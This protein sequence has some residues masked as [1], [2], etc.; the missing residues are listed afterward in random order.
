VALAYERLAGA[1]AALGRTEEAEALAAEGIVDADRR[2]L[3]RTF[4]VLLRASAADALLELG[5]W[6]EAAARIEEGLAG[7]PTGIEGV[8]LHV[9]AARLACGQ[10]EADRAVTHLRAARELAGL[11]PDPDVADGPWAGSLAS[12]ELQLA[13]GRPARVRDLADTWSTSPAAAAW[14]GQRVGL[15]LAGLAAESELAT[16]ARVHGDADGLAEAR[17]RADRLCG[18]AMAPWP[19]ATVPL[20]DALAATAQAERARMDGPVAEA[21]WVAVA[22]A[23]AEAGRTVL[24]AEMELRAAESAL[25]H[26]ERS[27]AAARLSRV[28]AVAVA[29]G[30]R[31]LEAVA[32]DLARR[33]RLDLDPGPGGAPA[34]AVAPDAAGAGTGTGLTSRELEVLSLLAEGRTNREIGEALFISPKT[35]S[36][37]VT[38]LLA[39]LGVAGRVEAATLALRMGIVPP[40]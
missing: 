23:W 8:A 18:A 3:D 35:V 4:G 26:G 30:V 20:R 12:A 32:R 22:A 37:H 5:R 16:T 9:V 39:K 1:L 25:S 15:L 27:S 34:G 36:V 21:T 2:G 24:A 40:H 19:G 17:G 31:P 10:G 33:A 38:N 14:P 29:A 6:P 7:V 13:I 28:L 11:P